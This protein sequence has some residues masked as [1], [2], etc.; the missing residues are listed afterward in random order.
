MARPT[1]LSG[2]V[3][4]KLKKLSVREH[5]VVLDNKTSWLVDCQP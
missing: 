4:R 3:Y 2:K 5:Q 1:V